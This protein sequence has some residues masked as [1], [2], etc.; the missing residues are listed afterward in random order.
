V[1]LFL[2]IQ[3]GND[4][5]GA[6]Q[7]LLKASSHVSGDFIWLLTF[8]SS[9]SVSGRWK[10]GLSSREHDAPNGNVISILVVRRSVSTF[11][12]RAASLSL[13]KFVVRA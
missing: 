12:L 1:V 4:G 7:P 9:A 6:D 3:I 5:V 8:G 11:A 10:Y 2:G 13:F